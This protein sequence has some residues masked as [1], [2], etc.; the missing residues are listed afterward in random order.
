MRRIV[1]SLLLLVGCSTL[2]F[3]TQGGGVDLSALVGLDKPSIMRLLDGSGMAL[4][5]PDADWPESWPPQLRLVYRDPYSNLTTMLWS[6]SQE[7]AY[8]PFY[9]FAFST[10]TG[11]GLDERNELPSV[12]Y[13]KDQIGPGVIRHVPQAF[14]YFEDGICTGI[15]EDSVREIIKNPPFADSHD[16]NW[17]TFYREVESMRFSM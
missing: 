13:L 9:S 8:R 10:E 5:T 6:M 7:G 4:L 17:Q 3:G 15:V 12:I 14:V 1:W 2:C 16:D 11:D